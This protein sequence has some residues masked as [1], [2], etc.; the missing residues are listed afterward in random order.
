MQGYGLTRTESAVMALHDSGEK[1]EAL[2]ARRLDLSVGRVSAIVR[3]YRCDVDKLDARY[4]ERMRRSSQS[5]L[6]ALKLAGMG[7]V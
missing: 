2:I 7:H 3:R 4:A 1:S 5:L 6:V